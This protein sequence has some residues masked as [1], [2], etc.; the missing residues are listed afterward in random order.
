MAEIVHEMIPN[1]KVINASANSL[2]LSVPIQSL[3]SIA[4]FSSLLE[5]D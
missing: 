3:D 1:S 2:V 5:N 4:Y